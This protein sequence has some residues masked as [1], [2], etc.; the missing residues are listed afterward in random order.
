MKKILVLYP[1]FP[2]YRKGIIDE[3]R[4]SCKFQFYF[5]GDQNNYVKNIKPYDFG[6]YGNFTHIKSIKK[7]NFVFHKGLLTHLLNN[8]YD[9][10]IVHAS[11]YWITIT[12][13]VFLLKIKGVKVFN[14]AHGLL[15]D[16]K[17]L[18]NYL[19]YL[20]F[21]I[22]DGILLYGSFAKNKALD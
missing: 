12:A 17:S 14:W 18:K 10:A 2:H 15:S 16:R 20:Y 6:E 5:V 19:Y 9:G 3:L 8:R 4:K 21:K 11:P 13:A 1:G 7:G 22:F